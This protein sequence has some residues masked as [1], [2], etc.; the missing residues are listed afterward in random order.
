MR[1]KITEHTENADLPDL[2][3]QQRHFVEGLLA[4]KSASD[5]YRAAYDCSEMQ[6]STIWANASRL[7]ANSNVA[8]WLAAARKAELGHSRITLDQHIKRLDELRQIAVE[9]GNV[10]AAV[11]AEQLIGKALGHYTEKYMEVNSDPLSALEQIA[12]EFG[13]DI[14]RQL[15]AK[16]GVNWAPQDEPP[17]SLN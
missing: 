9:S 2:T 4:G 15:A 10:G 13:P 7:R 16:E 1:R 5:A 11:Q 6:S 12:K 14:A 3:E 8:A 17:P